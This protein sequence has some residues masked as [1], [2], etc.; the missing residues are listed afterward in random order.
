[1]LRA[2]AL[3]LCALA[4][5]AAQAEWV[6]TLYTGTSRTGNSNLRVQQD[7]TGSDATFE[8]IHWEARPFEDAPYY[9]VSLSYFPASRPLWGGGFDF[10][11]YKMYADNNPAVPVKDLEISHGVNLMALNVVRRWLPAESS[12][13]AIVGAG[14][15]GY[16]PHAE[17]V[18]NDVSV[19]GDYQWGGMAYQVFAGGEYR[20]SK[21]VGVLLE[22]KF[23]AGKLDIDLDAG[24]RLETHTRT[25]HVIGGLSVHF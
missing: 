15:G 24:T 4:S 17:G 3:V 9:G 5:S 14:A 12:V 21:R 23:D 1:V 10:T 22:A 8:G 16:A 13:E 2:F 18:I 6:L 11:H 25:V 19:A 20:F 7:T